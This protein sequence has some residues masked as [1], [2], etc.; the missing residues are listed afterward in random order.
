MSID[1]ISSTFDPQ[2]TPWYWNSE[3]SRREMSRR[4]LEALLTATEAKVA[5]LE[6]WRR[7]EGDS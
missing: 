3:P 5:R 2:R 1:V 6:E 7:T 4:Q